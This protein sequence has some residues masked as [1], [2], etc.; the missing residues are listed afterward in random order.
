MKNKNNDDVRIQENFLVEKD[1]VILRDIVTSGEFPW[2][3]N[4]FQVY[5]EEDQSLSPGKFY[6]QIYEGNVPYTQFYN[7]HLPIMH[8][9]KASILMRIKIN[10]NL[11]LSEPFYSPFHTDISRLTQDGPPVEFITTSIFYI[12]T[13]N[14]YTEFEDGTK[15][16]SVANRLITFPT[17]T[18]HRGVTQTDKQ[19]RI[20]INFNYVEASAENVPPI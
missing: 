17:K 20:V 13:N 8:K 16:E 6:H 11:R 1:F 19:T 9:L 7:H 3:F 2:F 14:G 18:K 15:I 4:P 5:D 12:N 10:L